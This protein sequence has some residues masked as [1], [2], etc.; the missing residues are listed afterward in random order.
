M[1]SIASISSGSSAW[2]TAADTRAARMKEQWFSKADSDGSGGVSADELKALLTEASERSGQDLGDA[3]T[4]LTQMDSDG[5]GS[6]SSDELDAG[7]R[8]LLPPPGSTV[9]FAQRREGAHG[10]GGLLPPPPPGAADE[11][12]D[13]TISDDDRAQLGQA[14]SQLLQAMDTDQDRSLSDAEAL[15]FGDA[16]SQALGDQGDSLDEGSGSTAGTASPSND[17]QRL[18]ALIEKLLAQYQQ[19]SATAGDAADGSAAGSPRIDTCA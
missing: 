5:D 9:D 4:A 11:Q 14:L 18:T 1:S 15:R 19:P 2:A 13:S 16:L 7:L 12:T 8:S 3:D 17:A 10:P 6:L